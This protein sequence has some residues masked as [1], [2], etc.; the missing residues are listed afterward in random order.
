MSQAYCAHES[1]N[2]RRF[3]QGG[4]PLTD[5]P[6]L[7]FPSAFSRE[8]IDRAFRDE[9]IDFGG[10]KDA[11]YTPQLILWA[12]L[13]QA[14]S[15]GVQRSC[16]A[17]VHRVIVLCLLCGL[18]PPSPDTGAYC[19]ARAKVTPG[20]LKRLALQM[21]EAVEEE[22]PEGWLWLGRRARWVDGTTVLA[23]DTPDNQKAWPQSASQQQGLG[24]PLLRMVLVGS[25]ASGMIHGLAVGPHKGKETGET[26]LL[27]EL[28]D[29]FREGDV[30]V[31]DSYYGSYLMI[32]LL[33]QRGVDVVMKLHHL[34]EF[35][36]SKGRRLGP[37]EMLVTW[38]RP[39]RPEWM[40]EATYQSLPEKLTLRLAQVR[41][42]VP[43]FRVEEYVIATTLTNPREYPLEALADLYFWRW[44]GELDIRQIKCALHVD[45]LRC[46]TPEMIQQ[47]LWAHALAYN[48][49]RLRMAQAALSGGLAGMAGLGGE[50]GANVWAR[51]GRRGEGL[52]ALAG[53]RRGESPVRY[54]SFATALANTKEMW[55]IGCV[56]PPKR[57][58][59]LARASLLMIASGRLPDRPFRVE[60]RAIKRRPK[61]HR[62][63]KKPRR[64]AQEELRCGA[65]AT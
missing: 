45:D 31:A 57:R 47:E 55:L 5:D 59:L 33:L 46:K 27:R 1:A 32:A 11:V 34:R 10:H 49:V 50:W 38:A 61:P 22:M 21:A 44:H 9:G 29:C 3:R 40:D 53:Q 35:D 2:T 54:L 19:R 30:L 60:P 4:G 39:A 8:A 56:G 42:S 20:V 15:H 62:L 13:S 37:G 43:G 12:L 28:F 48:L 24:F 14:L 7:P 26:A 41:V 23:P 25:L 58:G 51:L 65:T 64:Q 18:R 63:L 6:E 16:K 17:A 52:A 36:W